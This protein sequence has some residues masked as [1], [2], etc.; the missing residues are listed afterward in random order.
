MQGVIRW[1]RISLVRRLLAIRR[2]IGMTDALPTRL[3]DATAYRHL[4][5]PGVWGIGKPHFA[6]DKLV[7]R[8]VLCPTNVVSGRGVQSVHLLARVGMTTRYGSVRGYNLV[9]SA[10]TDK[11][12]SILPMASSLHLQFE[13][14]QVMPLI[15]PFEPAGVNDAQ[16]AS[17]LAWMP[18]Q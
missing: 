11:S 13:R 17:G 3:Q 5:V 6:S 18:F 14:G 8:V 15:L 12:L 7:E 4:M 10:P 16:A 1:R 9:P 2:C